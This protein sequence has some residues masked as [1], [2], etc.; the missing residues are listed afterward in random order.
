VYN[1]QSATSTFSLNAQSPLQVG[2]D[3]VG[4]LGLAISDDGTIYASDSS[5]STVVAFSLSGTLYSTSAT[6]SISTAPAAA[7]SSFPSYICVTP[8][9]TTLVVGDQ[10]YGTPREAH[11]L[12]M[13]LPT[14]IDILDL[15]L[16][17]TC[18][19]VWCSKWTRSTVRVHSIRHFGILALPAS[20]HCCHHFSD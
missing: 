20:P 18:V 1:F 14:L 9:G 2:T 7:S 4:S 12:M 15:R 5:S 17:R 19:Y 16:F 8:S 6:L 13:Q 3:S 10:G 11:N